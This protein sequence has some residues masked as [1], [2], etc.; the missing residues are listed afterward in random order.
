MDKR[1]GSVSPSVPP[2]RPIE[3]VLLK[4]A[5]Y[6]NLACTYCYWFRDAEVYKLPPKLRPDVADAFVDRLD[7][8]LARYDLDEF[9]IIFHGGEPLLLGKNRFIKLLL[10]I[11]AVEKKHQTNISLSIQTNGALLDKEWVEI[12]LYF[13]IQIGI[14]IDGDRETHDKNRPDLRGRPTYELIRQKARLITELGGEH[15]VIAVCSPE[16]DPGK[17]IGAIRKDFGVKYL[18]VLIPDMNHTNWG[19]VKSIA[20]YYIRLFDIWLDQYDDHEISV[21]II[22]HFILSILGVIK[23]SGHMGLAP[24][25]SVIINTDGSIGPHDV[26]SIAGRDK[27]KTDASVFTHSLQDIYQDAGW[28]SV[29]QQS[30]TLPDACKACEYQKIC[31]GGFIGHRWSPENGYNNPSVYCEDYK[32]IIDHISARLGETVSIAGKKL[33]EYTSAQR[34]A[35][36]FGQ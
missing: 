33:S 27:I 15:T 36:A 24:Q 19:E 8:H 29:Y 28:L 31:G 14:S 6:C 26:L 32:K 23:G 25:D 12:L 30:K 13:Q 3:G 16:S 7:E 2:S 9:A 10:K 5:S 22:E 21:C 18:D 35:Q 20:N 4:T 34:L 1:I 17:L 11:K